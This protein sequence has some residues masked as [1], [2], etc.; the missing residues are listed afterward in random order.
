MGP[1]R[2]RL[3]FALGFNDIRKNSYQH[4]INDQMTYLNDLISHDI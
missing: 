4:L 2:V 3:C 1:E